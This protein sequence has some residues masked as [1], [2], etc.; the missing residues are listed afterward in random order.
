MFSHTLRIGY[1]MGLGLFLSSCADSTPASPTADAVQ[2]A[3]LAAAQRQVVA[4]ALLPSAK[5]VDDADGS[6]MVRLRAKCPEGFRVVE[7]P[8]TVQQGPEFGEV[9]GEGFFTTRCTGHWHVHTVRVV[10]PDGLNPGTARASA[11]LDVENPETG[12]ILGG[13]DSR[14]VK[15]H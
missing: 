8:V 4:V 11:S 6:L 3:M 10:A 15:I 9:F 5:L 1:A 7:G 12:E 14:V 2:P 13:S